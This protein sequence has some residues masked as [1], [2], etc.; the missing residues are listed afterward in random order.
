MMSFTFLMERRGRHR[1]QGAPGA[2]TW[3]L[4]RGAEKSVNG[5]ASTPGVGQKNTGTGA[6]GNGV[7]APKRG[8]SPNETAKTKETTTATTK[9]RACVDVAFFSPFIVVAIASSAPPQFCLRSRHY[10]YALLQSSCLPA[11]AQKHTVSHPAVTHAPFAATSHGD[12]RR[13]VSSLCFLEFL[14]LCEPKLHPL[15]YERTEQEGRLKKKKL[16]RKLIATR[17]I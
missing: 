11:E 13:T 15:A 6:R 3:R 12:K 1:R 9:R 8:Q 16:F 2:C 10:F 5:F 14:A 4:S 17:S 7:V